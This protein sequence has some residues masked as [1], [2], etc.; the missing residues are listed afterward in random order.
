MNNFGIAN[1]KCH[2]CLVAISVA[3]EQEGTQNN[4]NYEQN[5]SHI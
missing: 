5:P 2:H 1:F 3:D 4:L